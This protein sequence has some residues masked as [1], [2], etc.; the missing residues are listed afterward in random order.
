MQIN[1]E[2]EKY[3]TNEGYPIEIVEY[4][5]SKDCSIKFENNYRINNIYFCQ[6]KRGN[7]K[8]PYHLSIHGVG[9]IGVGRHIVSKNKVHSKSYRTWRR[10]YDKCYSE[11]YHKDHPTYKNC[12]IGTEW[13][14][15]Q[16]FGDWFEENWK[17]WMDSSWHLDKDLLVKGNK[18]YSSETCCI[19][20]QE[21]NNIFVKHTVNCEGTPVNIRISKSRK[22]YEARIRKEGIATHLKTCETL[23]EAFKVHKVAKEI[24]I[25]EIADKWKGLIAEKAYNAMYNWEVEITD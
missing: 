12:T 5:S 15:F 3:V 20:P 4:I 17:P 23:E 2:G 21:I 16:V 19:V 13:H 18:M 7:I 10:I 22:K 14:N 8:N 11:K 24:R 1:R 25:K 9:F 6:A